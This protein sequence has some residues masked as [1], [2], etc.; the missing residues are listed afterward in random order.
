[1]ET[2]YLEDGLR[3][4]ARYDSIFYGAFSGKSATFD[5]RVR[6]DLKKKIDLK[7]FQKA[8]D[9]ALR[10]YP[11]F[12]VRPVLHEGRVCYEPNDAPVRL[13]PDDGRSL[14]FG[15]DG[16]NGTNGYLFAFLYGEKYVTFSLFHGLTDA[17]GMIAYLISA[18]W[19]YVCAVFPPIRLAGTKMFTKHGIRITPDAFYRMSE[20]ERYDPLTMFASDEPLVTPVDPE[21]MFVLPPEDYDPEALSCRVI[22]LEIS[23]DAFL[24][25]TKM[26]DTSFAPLLAAMTGEA[27]MDAYDVGDKVVS[28]SVT[29]DP[30]KQLGTFSFGNMSYN[31]PLPMT[32]ADKA[33]TLKELCARLRA[34]M[35]KQLTKENAQANFQLILSQCDQIDAMGDIV[36]VN[37]LIT[38]PGGGAHL[39]TAATIFL[40]YPGRIA[41]NPISRVLLEG[42]TPGMLAVERGVVVYAHRDSL[43]VQIT[44]KG[45]DLTLADAME[46]TLAKNGFAPKRQDMGRVPQNV[47]DLE[48][49][50]V[51]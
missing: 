21:T 8:A 31:C 2:Y 18:L 51:R 23:N 6:F 36:S 5:I 25:R 24:Q 43:I 49:L 1:M 41:N 27:I 16:E 13:V 48:T 19:N 29:A 12:C 39:S 11:E 10:C 33:L 26:L 30:R 28:V 17:R 38:A 35:K 40:T 14:R 37:K 20:T 15:T 22:N 4:G 45:D 50:K 44:Q 32:K 47:L 3:R 9:K 42:V 34:D 7:K 46:R